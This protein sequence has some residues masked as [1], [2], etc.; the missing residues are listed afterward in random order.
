MPYMTNLDA[1]GRLGDAAAIYTPDDL[2]VPRK[3]VNRFPAAVAFVYVKTKPGV[4]RLISDVNEALDL[5]WPADRENVRLY[6]TRPDERRRLE[7]PYIG[8]FVS[9]ASKARLPTS[10]R[11]PTKANEIERL[12][13]AVD[14]AMWQLA[15]HDEKK[16]WLV[17]HA[18]WLGQ[19]IPINERPKQE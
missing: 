19:P 17:L 14:E 7:P 11:K 9:E 6:L 2:Y 8:P 12:N 5:V 4:L 18:A 1:E 16:A 13:A 10:E 3:F 15:H